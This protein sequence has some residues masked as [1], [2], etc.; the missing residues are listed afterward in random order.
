[1]TTRFAEK[2][3]GLPATAALLVDTNVGR[4]A[5]ALLAGRGRHAIAVGSGG[6]AVTAA[7]LARCRETLLGAS[8]AV[9][10]P[11][12]LVLGAAEIAEEH[13]WLFSAG[14]DNGDIVAAAAAARI[15]TPARIDLVTRRA[16]GAAARTLSTLSNAAVHTVP[17]AETKDGFLATHSLVATTGA[18]LLACDLVSEDPIGADL[19]PA[20]VAAVRN[21]VG[22]TARQS[23]REMLA[24]LTPND[25]LVIIA[26][27]QLA[28]VA[29]LIET[30]A[31]ETALCA[32]Q[33]TDP[34]NLAHGR[35]TW[36]HH[37]GTRTFMLAL[38][39]LDTRQIWAEVAACLPP[40]IR[41][42]S[43]DFGDCGRFRNAV[44]LVQGLVAVEAIGLAVGIDPGK[45][46]I[47]D[48]GQA[49]YA[50]DSLRDMSARLGAAV[51]QKRA[52]LLVRDDPAHSD[53]MVCGVEFQRLEAMAARP[54]G[55]I[56]LDY[57]GT[58]VTNDARLDPPPRAVVDE[59]VRLHRAGVVVAIATGRGGSAGEMLREVLP[60]DMH[61]HVLVGYYNGGYLQPL[62][63][64]I[65]V[66]PAPRNPLV[67][68]TDTWL[69]TNPQLFE[70]AYPGR[71]SG[72]QIAIP[73]ADLRRP[74]AFERDVAGCG[75]VAS[76]AVRISRSG[77]SYDLFPA[78]A[79]KTAVVDHVREKVGEGP[80][81]ICV[82]DSGA[83]CGND[84][85][86][87]SQPF[88]ISVGGV[89]GRHDG[90][91]SLF[92]TDLTGPDAL[93]R[94]LGAFKT[95]GKGETL[96]DIT[97]L[98]LDNTCVISTYNEHD[99]AHTP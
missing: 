57:D 43:M 76:G 53:T 55:G 19:A 74:E 78:T 99:A 79:S 52:A 27:P 89:C 98:G 37:R 39:G 22:Q 31:W 59:L 94:L 1:M 38:T 17:V 70:S 47:G 92:G 4:I 35:H 30:S 5:D 3:D 7:F 90:C 14:A 96:L 42:A 49:L 80:A 9:A 85:E 8:T 45:P 50:S 84:N 24:S 48:F 54:I 61:A 62:A 87:L 97:A 58:I 34:R 51:R 86:M 83:R 10:T 18:L 75:P 71:H 25:T 23:A 20:F 29:A 77:H 41:H 32:V 82:G 88:G 2:L 33:R 36:L 13:L 66:Q 63:V 72:V 15:R 26:D 69:R 60:R 67:A 40:G 46:G 11:M 16:D 64:D 6:S 21:A 12:E 81:I 93:V 91:W 56:V 28:A 73:L 95:D 65:V 44:G 68:E